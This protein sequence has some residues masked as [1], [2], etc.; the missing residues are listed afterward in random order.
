MEVPLRVDS[1][2]QLAAS[3]QH[4]SICCQP[5]SRSNK[6]L[7]AK[8]YC[9]DCSEYLCRSCGDYHTTLKALTQHRLSDVLDSEVWGRHNAR[10]TPTLTCKAHPDELLKY[11]CPDQKVTSCGA[12]V[13]LS[14]PTCTP[15]Y[16]PDISVGYKDS[17]QFRDFEANFNSLLEKV[18]AFLRCTE[19][20]IL[21]TTTNGQQLIDEI[22]RNREEINQYLLRKEKE[23]IAE[24][25][26]LLDED[27]HTLYQIQND[28]KKME[29]ELLDTK[30]KIKNLEEQSSD[31]FITCT[32]M[33]IRTEEME[34]QIDMFATLNVVYSYWARKC[35]VLSYLV[36]PTHDD[37]CLSNIVR[38]PNWKVCEM[39]RQLDINH[40]CQKN[41]HPGL[42]TGMAFSEPN[43][44]LL[45]DYENNC[46]KRVDTDTGAITTNVHLT[47]EPWDITIFGIDQAAVTLP[48][49][50]KIQFISNKAARPLLRTMKVDGRCFG[51]CSTKDNKLVVTF[52]MPAKVEVLDELGQVIHR[53]ST[54]VNGEPL[55]VTP[56]YV[57]FGTEDG[58]GT[59]YVSDYGTSVLTKLSMTGQVLLTF[60]DGDVSGPRGLVTTNDGHVIVCSKWSDNVQVVSMYGRKVRTLICVEDWMTDLESI[61]YVASTKT[62]YV[63]GVNDTKVRVYKIQ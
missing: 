6:Q 54:D 46:I 24:T 29:N 22:R 21:K 17:N 50:E 49:G 36:S 19:D 9:M 1:Q 25:E 53:L 20:N 45:A 58:Q 43:S 30:I 5:C 60:K 35:K 7:P 41:K 10:R 38:S 59:I 47:G 2:E 44:L 3:D 12:C 18:A 26:K 52:T 23:I 27:L 56:E 11:Y 57:S 34:A 39:V 63:S 61:C 51:I 14:R 48:F 37:T 31:L 33:M 55:F 16:I 8:S 62:L 28:V 42:I 32:N 40:T 13:I 4:D 15:E